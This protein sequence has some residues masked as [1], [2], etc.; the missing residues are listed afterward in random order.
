ME[1][2][3]VALRVDLKDSFSVAMMAA[4]K[5]FVKAVYLVIV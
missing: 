5:A 4:L 1:Y 2:R 3:W